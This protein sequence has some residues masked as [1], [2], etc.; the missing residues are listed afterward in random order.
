[1]TIKFSCEQCGEV[2]PVIGA[3]FRCEKC[4]GVFTVSGFSP[5][6]FKTGYKKGSGIWR[7]RRTFGFPD[8]VTP[9]TLGE[10]NTPLIWVKVG[11]RD[12]G[13]K[14]EFLNPTGSFKDRGSS[15]IA[16][17]IKSRGIKEAVEDSS[18]IP[19]ELPDMWRDTLEKQTK[20]WAERIA[21]FFQAL[22][23]VK[24]LASKK[25]YDLSKWQ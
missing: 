24:P 16:A 13:I 14:C 5:P 21:E 19:D 10:G 2:Y 11:G 18:G 7:F 20:E 17:F 9:V 22:P 6:E 25:R 12:V 1:M 8:G 3:P 23:A 15:L 4:G